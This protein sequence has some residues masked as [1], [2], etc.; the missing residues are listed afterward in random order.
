MKSSRSREWSEFSFLYPTNDPPTDFELSQFCIE[1]YHFIGLHKACVCFDVGEAVVIPDNWRQGRTCYGGLT[2]ALMYQGAINQFDDLP[3]L[4]SAL[5]NFVGPVTAHPTLS[6]NLERRG[7]NG[8]NISAAAQINIPDKAEPQTV[9]RA[10]FLFGTSR[11]SNI[12][13]DC[14]APDAIPREQAKPLTPEVFKEMVPQ[15]F[16]NFDTRLIAGA[17]PMMGT[18]G[19]I[20][21]WSRHKDPNS[22]EGTGSLICLGDVLPPA[23]MPLMRNIAPVSS[24]SWIFNLLV[25]TPETEDGWWHVESRLTAAQGGYTSQAMRIWNT[26]GQLIV[27]GM[28]SIAI[29]DG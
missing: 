23:A 26:E 9:G 28:Q 27:E 18:E 10:D 20:R 15:F 21:A 2:A 22:R 8:T 29:F 3:P 17:R 12:S 24:M 14:P 5:I 1:F 6:A 19:Y 4:R 13:V 11:N 16:L 25:D 7:R